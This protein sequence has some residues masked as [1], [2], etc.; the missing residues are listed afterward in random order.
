[1]SP[2]TYARW[3]GGPFA[4]SCSR[5]AAKLNIDALTPGQAEFS[6]RLQI[7][8]MNELLAKVA[9]HLRSAGSTHCRSRLRAKVEHLPHR[10]IKRV[11]RPWFT[12]DARHAVVDRV[13][14]TRHVGRDHR[15]GH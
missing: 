3:F 11:D 2:T 9:F 13:A 8:A 6:Q 5:R 4:P 15:E 12:D 7:G 10:S 1:M 14:A